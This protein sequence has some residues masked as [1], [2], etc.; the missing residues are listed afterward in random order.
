MKISVIGLGFVGRVT[1]GSLAELGHDVVGVDLSRAGGNPF[2]GRKLI[3]SWRRGG[4]PGA[5]LERRMWVRRGRIGVVV[6]LR[7]DASPSRWRAGH[8]RHRKRCRAY[9]SSSQTGASNN[10]LRTNAIAVTHDHHP[11]QELKGSNRLR[12]RL[13]QMPETGAVGAAHQAGR[14]LVLTRDDFGQPIR[15]VEQGL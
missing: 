14:S 7:G 11:D 15:C 12:T 4:A 3:G 10:A 1:G 6:H 9:N 13:Q 8:Q 5:S 2:P